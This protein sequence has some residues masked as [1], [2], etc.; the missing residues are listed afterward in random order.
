M[1]ADDMGCL[2]MMTMAWFEHHKHLTNDEMLELG[3][4]DPCDISWVDTLREKENLE[5]RS[6]KRSPS[7]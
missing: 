3:M 4:I 7:R 5:K 1:K 2:T 6:P